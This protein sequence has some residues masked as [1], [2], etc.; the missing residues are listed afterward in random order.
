MMAALL[1]VVA[2][3]VCAATQPSNATSRANVVLFLADDL[4]VA[5]GGLLPLSQTRKLLA[6]QGVSARHFYATT[7]VRRRLLTRAPSS[8]P[9]PNC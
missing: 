9:S 8:P 4:D 6:D 7:P 3:S 1:L 2:C 5:L